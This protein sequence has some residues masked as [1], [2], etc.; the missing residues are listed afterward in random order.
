M[1]FPVRALTV[2]SL[3]VEDVGAILISLRKKYTLTQYLANWQKEH[4]CAGLILAQWVH[5]G[6][7]FMIVALTDV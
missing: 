2:Y 7:S 4:W 3:R 1:L 5:G 6:C